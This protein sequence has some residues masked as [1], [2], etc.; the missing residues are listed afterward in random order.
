[1]T[2]RALRRGVQPSEIDRLVTLVEL[3]QQQGDSFETGIQLALQAILISPHFLFRVELDPPE[4]QE[5][6]DLNDYE[7]A[8]R[9]S[10]FL[11]SSMPDEQLFQLARQGALRQGNNL[12]KQV[13]RMLNDPKSDAFIESF[14]GQ[15]LQLRSLE[16]MAFDP[17]RF[18]GCDQQLLAAMRDETIRFFAEIVRSDL[19]ILTILD[20]DFTFVN[21]ALARHYGI[22]GVKGN[23][24]RRV[25]LKG[26]PRGGVM[27]QGSI[28]AVTSNPTRTS[29][30]KRGKFILENL[31]G[32]PPPPPPP[33]VPL[34]DDK[35]RKLTGTLRQQMEQ[36]RTN[37]SC[38]S[39]HKLMDPLGFALENF[40]AVGRYRQQDEGGEIDPSGELPSGETFSGYDELRELLLKSKREQFLKCMSEKMLIYAVGRGL[41]YYD[42]C[43]VNKIMNALEE[44]DYRFSRLV[45]E[46]V[47]SDPFQK[48]GKKRSHE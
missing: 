12:E 14:A 1:L 43:A 27:T 30:V 41:E 36:H 13:R 33:N 6:R 20:A 32:T 7:L 19:S 29:P 45:L 11:W 18:P 35:G 26:T 5:E 16:D 46:V 28:L 4:G 47:K 2:T 37:P 24:W 22:A 21:E 8:T 15:W 42:Q 10:Y 9:M 39:C 44:D 38:A 23:E 3:A 31:L 48:Q 34:L 25:S 17:Q 40:D